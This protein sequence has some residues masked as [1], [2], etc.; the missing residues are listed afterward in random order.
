M[1]SACVGVVQFDDGEVELKDEPCT[2][3][4]LVI[5]AYQSQQLLAA[6]TGHPAH[7]VHNFACTSQQGQD[8]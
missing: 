8:V 4:W 1:P 2:Y 5:V 7:L 6:F 3:Q